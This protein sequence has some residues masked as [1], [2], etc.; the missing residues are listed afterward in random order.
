MGRVGLSTSHTRFFVLQ[1]IGHAVTTLTPISNLE[2]INRIRKT[3]FW[4]VCAAPEK[5]NAGLKTFDQQ[6]LSNQKTFNQQLLSSQKF[7][8]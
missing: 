2:F 7:S 6:L 4:G 5:G 1:N 3:R 8:E